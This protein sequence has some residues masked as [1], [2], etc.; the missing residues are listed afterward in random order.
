MKRI[1]W[2]T[3]PHVYDLYVNST[4]VTRIWGKSKALKLAEKQAGQLF[5]QRHVELININTGEIIY[6]T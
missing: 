4:K 5:E 2:E 1:N 6:S 3:Y